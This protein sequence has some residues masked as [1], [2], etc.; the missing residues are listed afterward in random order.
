MAKFENLEGREFGFWKVIERAENHSSTKSAQWLCE[1]E[2][3]TKRIIRASILKSGKSKSCGCHKNDYNRIHG[4]KGT[5]LYEIWRHMIYRCENPENQAYEKY[6]GR[7]ITV[8]DEWHDFVCFREW[9]MENGYKET[10]SIDR[11]DN[12]KGYCPD[13]CRWATSEMQMNNRRMCN[14][15]EFNGEKLT[16]SQWAKKTG[17]PRSTLL[18]RIKRGW[19]IEKVLTEPIANTG[20]KKS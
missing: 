7:G 15:L 6:G 17:I 19:N 14:V 11:I 2:C 5:R 13:N 10:L 12:N 18:N 8:C 16:L 9:A 20:R 1:C 4:G 3:G